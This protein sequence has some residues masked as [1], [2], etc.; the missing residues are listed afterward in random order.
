[1]L[2]LLTITNQL[3]RGVACLKNCH[4]NTNGFIAK[5]TNDKAFTRNIHHYTG[6]C[7]I[8]QST[9]TS[10]LAENIPYHVKVYPIIH[11]MP[12]PIF[13][14]IFCLKIA[15]ITNILW[16]E[17]EDMNLGQMA[18]HVTQLIKLSIF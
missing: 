14:P 17:M 9:R 13:E 5:T 8:F 16:S 12:V 11:K 3:H 15:M 7:E 4:C 18:L 2:W 1:M 10:N 6:Y